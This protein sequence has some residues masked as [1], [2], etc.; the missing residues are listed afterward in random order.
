MGLDNGIDA[1]K[2]NPADIPGFVTIAEDPYASEKGTMEVCYWRKCWGIR[3]MVLGAIFAQNLPNEK[4]RYD[5]EWKEI[6]NIAEGLV[7]FLDKEYFDTYAQSIWEYEEMQEQLVQDIIN[8]KWLAWYMKEH[9]D[10]E[11]S[12]YDSY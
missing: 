4:Y 10:V 1:K 12:F 2:I 6:E 11:A 7:P 3:G 8:L 5:L 9:P